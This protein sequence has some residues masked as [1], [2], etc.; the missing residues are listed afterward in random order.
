M[1]DTVLVAG[2]AGVCLLA[3][4]MTVVRLPGTWMI[5]IAAAGFDWWHGWGRVGT[6][7]LIILAGVAVVAEVLELM[8][9]VMVARRAGASRRSAWGGMLGGI[10]GMIFLSFLVP[11]PILGTLI[12]ALLGCFGGALLMELTDHG[13]LDQGTKVGLW[14]AIGM[15]LGTVTKT[16]IACVMAGILMWAVLS[17]TTPSTQGIPLP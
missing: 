8:T 3:V 4:L 13:R 10:G 11:I 14:S 5:V 17:P 16:A 2:L 9:S 1:W 6:T 15:A 12:G 7:T